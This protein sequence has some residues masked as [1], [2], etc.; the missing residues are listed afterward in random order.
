M[1]IV[2]MFYGILVYMY[3]ED[4]DRHNLPHIHAK[5]AEFEAVLS[6][7][8]ARLLAGDMPAKKL[9]QLEVWIDLHQE[10]L[11]GNWELAL[12]NEELY[13]IEPLK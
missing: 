10:E 8:D 2:S 1:P 5:Y 6:I 11:M 12:V 4:S 13:R 7:P 9:K 3:F